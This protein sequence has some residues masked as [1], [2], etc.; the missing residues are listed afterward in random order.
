MISTEYKEFKQRA[1]EAGVKAELAQL[2]YDVVRDSDQHGWMPLLRDWTANEEKMIAL[3]LEQPEEMAEACELLFATDGLMYDEGQV[4]AGISDEKRIE[5]E[6]WIFTDELRE[7][8][9]QKP[10]KV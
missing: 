4:N 3:A 9:V 8:H 6:K 2:M 5:I 7:N 10:W 1:I